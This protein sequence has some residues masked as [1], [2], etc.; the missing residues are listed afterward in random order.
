MKKKNNMDSRDE[1]RSSSV[2]MSIKTA[3]VVLVSKNTGTLF[4]YQTI[5]IN[6][7]VLF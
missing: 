6:E 2:W 7:R 5:D 4:L 3:G 1:N